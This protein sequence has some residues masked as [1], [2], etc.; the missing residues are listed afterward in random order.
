MPGSGIK[1]NYSGRTVYDYSGIPGFGHLKNVINPPEE[2]FGPF[3]GLE[4]Y[5]ASLEAGQS[6]RDSSTAANRTGQDQTSERER[7]LTRPIRGMALGD[8]VPVVFARRRTGGTGGV[9]IQP[10]ATEAQFSNTATTITARYHCLLSEGQLGSIQT[11]DV[12]IGL[13]RRGT[14]SQNYGQRAG[15]WLSGNRSKPV[16]GV[17]IPD[18]PQNCGIGGNYKGVTTFEYSATWPIGSDNWKLPANI[19][20]RQGMQIDRGRLADNVVGPSDNICDLI[21]WALVKSGR[22]KESEINLTEMAKTATFIEVNQLFCNGE[23]TNSTSLPDFLVNILPA[24][25]LRETTID[26]KYC[27][28]PAVPVNAD[29]TIKTMAI[30]PDSVLTEESIAPGSWDQRPAP[31]DARGPLQLSVLWRQQTNDLEPPLDRDLQVGQAPP[32]PVPQV[33]QFD[34][35][36]FCVSE[37]HAALAGGFRHALR[38]L[39]GATASVRI[40]AGGQSGYLRQGQVVQIYLQVVSELEPIGVINSLWWIDRIDLAEDHSESLQLSACPVDAQGRSLV[41]LQVVAARDNAPGATLPYPPLAAGDEPGRSADTSVPPSSTVTGRSF[42]E[43][44]GGIV[45]I[46]KPGQ[47]RDMNRTNLP[48]SP[49]AAPPAPPPGPPSVLDGTD[50]GIVKAGDKPKKEEEKK[51]R[52]VKWWNPYVPGM[53]PPIT[54]GAWPGECEFGVEVIRTR[55]KGIS[56]GGG[57]LNFAIVNK[58]VET[59]EQVSSEL[60]GASFN[61]D[62][63]NVFIEYYELTYFRADGTEE[64]ENIASCI[65]PPF[66][67]GG[68]FSL[69]LLDWRC[70]LRDG[71]VGPLRTPDS[72]P[73]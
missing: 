23:F 40:L 41:A 20:I 26:G 32:G 11:R 54:V 44:G 63:D 39:A 53:V 29:G 66:G 55:V 56:F 22:K 38:T 7:N 73:L 12:R 15:S 19:F 52:G 48:P 24:F 59:I 34:L 6:N 49:P 33:E 10:R 72:P 60:V 67:E 3:G 58:I 2:V 62:Y 4:K 50:S 5:L 51:R 14:F 28:V 21:I 35:R 43:G 1:S 27:V 61:P 45:L 17:T 70:K 25:L 65:D 42:S 9:M 18:F 37:A 31:A 71:S 8:P 47:V 69:Q 13:Y 30:E 46:G 16:A 57:G 68:N 64:K 36:G